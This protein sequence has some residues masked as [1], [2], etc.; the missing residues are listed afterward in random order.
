MN[1]RQIAVIYFIAA[2]LF[3]GSMIYSITNGKTSLSIVWL[4]LASSN[5]C[6][7]SVW[8]NKK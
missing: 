3:F 1:N 4:C 8:M 5:L 2:T 7:G 6:L